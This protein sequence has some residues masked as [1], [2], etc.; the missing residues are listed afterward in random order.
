MGLVFKQIQLINGDLRG[1]ALSPR[2]T[3]EEKRKPMH[4]GR[5][6][7]K[8]N[9]NALIKLLAERVQILNLL[10]LQFAPFC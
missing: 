1:T 8:S 7:E 3:E 5:V 9:L 4:R 2:M 10:I 6:A